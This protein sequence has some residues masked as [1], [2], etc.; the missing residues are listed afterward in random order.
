MI[1][2]IFIWSRTLARWDFLQSTTNRLVALEI[3]G[4]YLRGA[5]AVDP[6]WVQIRGESGDVYWDSH[7]QSESAYV[8]R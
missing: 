1:Y 4:R 3:A 2:K 5:Y 8:G 7:K 6:A